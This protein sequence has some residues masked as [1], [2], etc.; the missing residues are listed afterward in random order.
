VKTFVKLIIP[1]DA[2]GRGSANEY[3][4]DSTDSSHGELVA[5]AITAAVDSRPD[6]EG[7]LAELRRHLARVSGTAS[8]THRKPSGARTSGA[9]VRYNAISRMT[10]KVVTVELR[11][12]D[13][14][15]V[16]PNPD[17]PPEN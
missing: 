15:P 16:A 17:E 1:P 14:T 12:F 10:D 11:H 5:A 9:R 3:V 8:R 2:E 6:F 7:R 13:K 4:V